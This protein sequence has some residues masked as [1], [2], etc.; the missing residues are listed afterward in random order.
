MM[1]ERICLFAS[2]VFTDGVDWSSDQFP[3]GVAVDA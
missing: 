1:C 3:C 2:Q